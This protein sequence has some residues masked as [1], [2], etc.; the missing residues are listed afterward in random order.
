MTLKNGLACLVALLALVTVGC[1]VLKKGDEPDRSPRV[2]VISLDALRYAFLTDPSY[3]TPTL[4]GLYAQGASSLDVTAVYPSVT[5]PSHTTLVTGAYPRRHGVLGNRVFTVKNGPSLDW[6]WNAADIK[7]QTLWQA[8]EAAGMRTALLNWPVSAGAGARWV[9]PEIFPRDSFA[10]DAIWRETQRFTQP[11]LMNELATQVGQ[12]FTDTLQKDR[13]MVEAARYLLKARRPD[14]LF[15]HLAHGDLVQHFN[16]KDS[17]QT[18]QAW[19]DIDVL[20][21]SVVDDLDL[22]KTCLLVVGDHGFMD[23]RRMIHIN[24]LFARKGWLTLNPNGTLRDWKVFAELNGGQASIYLRDPALAGRVRRLLRENSAGNYRVLDRKELDRLEAFPDAFVALEPLPGST[25]GLK[26][27]GALVEPLL[28]THGEHGFAPGARDV[29]TSLVAVGPCASPG[30][31]LGTVQLVD[32]APTVARLLGLT[33]KD[34]QG[35][36]LPLKDL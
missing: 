18:H 15:L 30:K 22:E 36:A 26:M 17:P 3:E 24:T 27:S 6:Y 7:T 9:V 5:Y 20:L 10:M 11:E 14:V 4:K 21:K 2:V 29:H 23:I 16:G 31:K 34:A 33:L 1:S 8:A 35:L 28:T 32:V 19:K 12:G 25:M 13:W